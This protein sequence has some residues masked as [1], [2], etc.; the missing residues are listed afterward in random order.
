[1]GLP[2]L[3]INASVKIRHEKT[4]NINGV[5]PFVIGILLL[6]SCDRPTLEEPFDSPGQIDDDLAL[7]LDSLAGDAMEKARQ[8]GFEEARADMMNGLA[9]VVAMG[10]KPVVAVIHVNDKPR[11][12]L[13]AGIRRDSFGMRGEHHIDY[14]IFAWRGDM[15]DEILFIEMFSSTGS[16]ARTDGY[17]LPLGK[18]GQQSATSVTATAHSFEQTGNSCNVIP[19]VNTLT[20][21]DLPCSEAK[22]QFSGSLNFTKE[23]DFEV[24]GRFDLRLVEVPLVFLI[25][26]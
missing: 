19:I 4:F 22:V 23:L 17:W 13:V 11:K 9:T 26:N 25:Q 2:C 16:P 21:S 14:R 10:A 6:W 12:Y 7:R 8:N 5:L 20:P 15:V 24:K 18:G 1:M 3:S